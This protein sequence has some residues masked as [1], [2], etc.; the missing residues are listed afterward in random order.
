MNM[1]P[2]EIDKTVMEFTT[3]GNGFQIRAERSGD[4]VNEGRKKQTLGMWRLAMQ[5]WSNDPRIAS[6]RQPSILSHT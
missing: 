1:G 2:G 4:E 3:L 5:L 6:E